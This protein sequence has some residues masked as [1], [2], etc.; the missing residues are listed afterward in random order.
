MLF[1][2]EPE[3]GS[4]NKRGGFLSVFVVFAVLSI[5][6]IPSPLRAEYSPFSPVTIMDSGRKF[7]QFSQ[8]QLPAFLK[9]WERLPD[10]A[11][12]DEVFMQQERFFFK[13]FD[14]YKKNVFSL[15]EAISVLVRVPQKNYKFELVL[16]EYRWVDGK[17][18][19]SRSGEPDVEILPEEF[20]RIKIVYAQKICESATYLTDF[21]GPETRNKILKKV[22]ARLV[23]YKVLEEGDDLEKRLSEVNLGD[24]DELGI[25]ADELLSI[26]PRFTFDHFAP[27]KA[28]ILPM[29]VEDGMIMGLC[30]PD[31]GVVIYH[32]AALVSDYLRFGDTFTHELLHRNTSLQGILITNQMDPETWTSFLERHGQWETFLYH[33][34]QT[35][36]RSVA[37]I[38]TSFD[39]TRAKRE[40]IG[41]ILGGSSFDI[42]K[43][44][45]KLYA[46]EGGRIFSDFRKTMFEKFM[47]EFYFDPLFWICVNDEL[48]DKN[49]AFKVFFYSNYAFSLLGGPEKTLEWLSGHQEIISQAY[50]KAKK[51]IKNKKDKDRKEGLPRSGREVEQDSG[52]LEFFAKQQDL[53]DAYTEFLGLPSFAPV[54]WRL[55]KIKQAVE[56]GWIT[57]PSVR[58]SLTKGGL[59]IEP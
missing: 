18:M 55:E 14:K 7:E 48:Y 3:G 23:T 56:M 42:N 50:E 33:P 4:M 2:K 16:A 17:I 13:T 41:Y 20:E 54:R 5:I 1:E 6:L 30:Y 24:L 34:Y 31:T 44:M 49:G 43:E 57:L 45:F 38:I 35:T 52:V 8:D 22:K 21:I 37:E 27:K 15:D 12:Y 32:P 9:E 51:T 46:E 29:P 39:T 47:P 19:Y 26:P 58:Y 10:T 40:M 59:D 25:T 36:S 11:S 28:I 53:V